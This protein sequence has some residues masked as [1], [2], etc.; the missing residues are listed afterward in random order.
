MIHLNRVTK[1]YYDKLILSVPEF[2]FEEG[3]TWIAGINGSGKTTLL[4]IMAGMIPFDGGVTLNGMNVKT[5]PVAYRKLVSYAEAEPLY[6]SFI[7]GAELV[8]YYKSIRS[9]DKYHVEELIAFSGLR[10]QLKNPVGTYSSGM[11][12]R[13]ALLLA[14]I[15]HVPVIILD[16]PFA[17]LDAE[18][19]QALPDLIVDYHARYKCS[20]IFSSHQA[21]PDTLDFQRKYFVY[22]Q[23][24]NLTPQ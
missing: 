9:A 12:K 13:L 23:A 1:H 8:A 17:T 21:V 24:I 3:T 4:K 11:V 19:I 22:N 14:F 18:G 2:T 16:E 7:T 5:D 6:P 15:G 20:F 10:R